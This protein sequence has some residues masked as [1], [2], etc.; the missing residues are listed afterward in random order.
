[1]LLWRHKLRWKRATGI[2]E[3]EREETLILPAISIF[4][5]EKCWSETDVEFVGVFV[6]GG[7]IFGVFCGECEMGEGSV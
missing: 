5:R 7:E 3:K 4:E 6:A 2:R 1:M